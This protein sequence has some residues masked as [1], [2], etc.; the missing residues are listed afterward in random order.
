VIRF[1]RAFAWLRWRL[2]VNGIKGGRRRD[3]LERLSRIG[4]LIVR[5]LLL[6]AFLVPTAVLG[7]L[8]LAAGW[9]AGGGSV[10]PGGVLLVARV[11]LLAEVLLVSLIAL[12]VA[13]SGAVGR[14]TRLLLLPIPRRSLHLVEALAGLADPWVAYLLPALVSFAVGLMLAGRWD[15]ALVALVGG[16][17]IVALLAS[18]GSLVSF[19]TSWLLRNRRRGEMFTLAFVLG[20]SLFAVVPV[21]VSDSLERRVRETRSRGEH[22]VPESIEQLGRALPAWSGA[23][24]SELY[25][26]SIGAAFDGRHGAAWFGVAALLLEAGALYG[27]S[28]AAHRKLI[29]STETGGTRRRAAVVAAAGVRLPGLTQAASAV[30]F[31]Q[32][33]TA[34]R[35]VRGRFVVLMPGPLLAVLALISRQLPGEFPGGGFLGSHGAAVLAMGILFSLFGLQGFNLNQFASDRAGLT[36]Q[37]L[38]PIPEAD[39]VRGKALG[40]GMILAVAVV[41]CLVCA[42]VVAPGDSPSVWLYVLLAG[43]S[44][45]MLVSPVAALL[46]ALFPVASDLS[47]TG[48]GGDPHGLAKLI[49]TL[50]VAAL[51]GPPALLLF[52]LSGR[53]GLALLI[54]A[55]WTL[56]AAAIS[57]PL[58]GL[59]AGAVPPR[60]EN[61][62]LVAQGR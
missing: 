15:A 36:L 51:A 4:A 17:G 2:L 32:A 38:A 7:L 21:L 43:A 49:G 11:L 9:M 30:A 33:R 18:L 42:L 29:E 28:S 47:K 14:S 24:P 35:T 10:A 41:P 62:A 59:A 61:L 57:I 58:L 23:L 39:L 22:P 6:L 34:L 53:P 26:R 52:L 40:C 1:L 19:L 48:S 60:R 13:P 54:M 45:Y 25:G 3:A 46:S 50:V 37:F 27:L 44:T 8:A 55:L 16:A 12:T 31:A 56:L 5:V 20:I